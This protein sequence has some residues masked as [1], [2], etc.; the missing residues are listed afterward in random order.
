MEAAPDAAPDSW[1]Q[2]L[3]APV[4]ALSGLN[5]NAAEFVPTFLQKDSGPD[6]APEPGKT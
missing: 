3:E 6:G 1:D 4:R 5:V 2:E